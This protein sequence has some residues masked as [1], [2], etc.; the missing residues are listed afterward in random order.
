[1]ANRS[2]H[3]PA[4]RRHALIRD[5]VTLKYI[6]QPLSPAQLEELPQ[7]PRRP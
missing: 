3:E 2:L 6:A 7:L 5:A 4:K 1:L